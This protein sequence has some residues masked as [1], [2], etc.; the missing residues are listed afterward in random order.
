M[1]GFCSCLLQN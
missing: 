1:K